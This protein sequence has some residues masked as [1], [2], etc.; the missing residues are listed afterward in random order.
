MAKECDVTEMV[1]S[2]PRNLPSGARHKYL[3]IWD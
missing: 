3:I 1:F 2:R